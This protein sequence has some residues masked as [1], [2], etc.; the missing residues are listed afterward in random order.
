MPMGQRRIEYVLN[1]H[2]IFVGL[3]RR[4]HHFGQLAGTGKRC[5]KSLTV[6]RADLIIRHQDHAPSLD[7]RLPN[8]YIGN[9]PATNLDRITPVRRGRGEVNMKCVQQLRHG[10]EIPGQLVT[11]VAGYQSALKQYRLNLPGHFTRVT[12]TSRDDDIC[13][14]PVKRIAFRHQLFQGLFSVSLLK[15]RPAFTRSGPF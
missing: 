12:A 5:F 3:S 1:G 11:I 7:Q 14:R 13:Q 2:H 15:Q 4:Q 6:N 10:N 8:R 9:Q